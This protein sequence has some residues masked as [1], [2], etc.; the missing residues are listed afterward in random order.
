MKHHSTSFLKVF[1]ALL[2]CLVLTPQDSFAQDFIVSRIDTAKFPV[3]T[4]DFTATD[5]AGKPRTGLLSSDFTVSENGIPIAA[6]LVK[7]T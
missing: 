1:F 4:A 2:C 7:L 3:I 6:N 5:A